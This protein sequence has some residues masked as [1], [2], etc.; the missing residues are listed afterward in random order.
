MTPAHESDNHP[1]DLVDYNLFTSNAALVDALEREGSG[2][3]HDRLR[4]LGS[5]LGSR[6]MFALGDAANRNP[7]VLKAFD[8]FGHRRDEVEFHPAWHEL[9]RTLVAEGLHTSPW[10]QPKSGAHV[11]RAAFL[12]NRH[13]PFIVFTRQQS[14]HPFTKM[15]GLPCQRRHRAIR[16]RRRALRTVLDFT[17]K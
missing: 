14:R 13:Q 3:A 6:A 1:H 10:A 11:E 16:H 9:M 8:R 4:D 5:R 12:R 2:A 7:P 15:L 17:P